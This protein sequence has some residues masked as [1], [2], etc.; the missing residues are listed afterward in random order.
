MPDATAWIWFHQG[1]L[2]SKNGGLECF[3]GF[4]DIAP[5]E[6]FSGFGQNRESTPL[7]PKS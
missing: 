5:D 4:A 3:L 7:S 1:V 6:F 2:T